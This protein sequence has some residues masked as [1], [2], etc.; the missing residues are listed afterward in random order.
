[1]ANSL[2]ENYVFLLVSV[3]SPVSWTPSLLTGAWISVFKYLVQNWTRNDAF[4]YVL[5]LV[6]SLAFEVLNLQNDCLNKSVQSFQ[7][8]P[9]PRACLRGGE[10]AESLLEHRTSTAL[11]SALSAKLKVNLLTKSAVNCAVYN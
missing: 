11:C 1:M 10:W 7:E 8:V 2:N 5:T 6:H 9:S 4:N 3:H